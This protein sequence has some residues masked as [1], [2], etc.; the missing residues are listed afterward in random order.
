M[1]RVLS[2]KDVTLKKY[3]L[4]AAPATWKSAPGRLQ[5]SLGPPCWIR[6]LLLD[7]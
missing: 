4:L 2:G 5:G 7:G 1:M 6:V 3:E